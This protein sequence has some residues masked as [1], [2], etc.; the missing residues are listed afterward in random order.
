[1]NLRPQILVMSLVIAVAAN[2]QATEL[3]RYYELQD[4]EWLFISGLEYRYIEVVYDFI[5]DE[6]LVNGHV[7][8]RKSETKEAHGENADSSPSSSDTA[9]VSAH[10]ILT[11]QSNMERYIKT[12]LEHVDSYFTSF[13]TKSRFLLLV[14]SP[15]G[16]SH[17]SSK[18]RPT[19]S[20]EQLQE[21][22]RTKS[23]VEGPM[24]LRQLLHFGF[25][26]EV[27]KSK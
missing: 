11:I 16:Q 10:K 17:R 12:P 3:D 27:S 9:M 20:I 14:I 7:F 4:N 22:I 15:N 21:V 13:G 23:F 19:E 18:D 26:I 8:W 5:N 6:V 25:E 24:G 2:V 1:V